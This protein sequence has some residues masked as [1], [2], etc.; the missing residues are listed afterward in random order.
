MNKNMSEKQSEGYTA[1]LYG[2]INNPYKTLTKE[3]QYWW[4]GWHAAEEEDTQNHEEWR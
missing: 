1:F 4:D 2:I 3:R